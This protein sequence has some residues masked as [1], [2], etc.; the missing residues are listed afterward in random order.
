MTIEIIKENLIQLIND[1]NNSVIALSGKWG[2]GKTYLWQKIIKE[3]AKEK[4][5]K[6]S[7]YVSL[8]G[9]KD[10]EQLKIRILQNSADFLSTENKVKE[11]VANAISIG[12][13]VLKKFNKNFDVLDDIAL[14]AV[15]TL[16]KKKLLVIDDVERKHE[17]F[18]LEEILGF[19]DE[20]SQNY[21][22]R[23]L[24]I[25]NIDQLAENKEKWEKF[26][27]KIIDHELSL[28]ITAN[29][30]FNIAIA[31]R[32]VKYTEIIKKSVELCKVNNIRIVY[33]IINIVNKLI[34]HRADLSDA[35]LNR[36]IPS[37]VLLSAIYFKGIED[38]PT[39]DFVLT[40][41]SWDEVI[42]DINNKAKEPSRESKEFKK[43]SALLH[44]LNIHGS[45]EYERFVVNFLKS[46]LLKKEDID[47]IINR[48]INEEGAQTVQSKASEFRNKY[49]WHPELSEDNLLLEAKEILND[50]HL[51]DAYTVTAIFNIVKDF[52][53]GKKLADRFIKKWLNYF[54]KQAHVNFNYQPDSFG[55]ELH[56]GIEKIFK[57]LTSKLNPPLSLYE[58]V[59]NIYHNSA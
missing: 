54:C 11:A 1:D 19:I 59:S 22:T 28:E 53:D 25:L 32:K 6:D 13:T 10:I 52:P 51:L 27:E 40:Y 17:A 43:W 21:K 15:P 23:F 29:E 7:L 31:T 49:F 39:I 2:T 48:Y 20:F 26:R 57:E 18:D 4:L 56:P 14:F 44:K 50:V 42:D 30:A 47:V 8:F 55:R 24:L 37:V 35:V 36:M 41:N 3:E 45:D 58:A 46:G 38:G 34:G 9:V 5:I 12:K 16:L 33:K